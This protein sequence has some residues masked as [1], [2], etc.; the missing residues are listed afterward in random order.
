MPCLYGYTRSGRY[1]GVKKVNEKSRERSLDA[2]DRRIAEAHLHEWIFMNG[3]PALP[4]GDVGE[5][6]STGP[7]SC[8]HGWLFLL[9]PKH[10]HR[11]PL[12]RSHALA[13]MDGAALW[14]LQNQAFPQPFASGSCIKPAKVQVAA[15]E[16]RQRIETQRARAPRGWRGKSPLARV[17]DQ[18][19]GN[20][21]EQQ[22]GL[23]RSHRR[24]SGG[25]DEVFST[26]HS[27]AHQ[28]GNRA[29]PGPR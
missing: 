10:T 7:C 24:L 22:M 18:K 25:P 11:H 21:K 9:T 1:Y 17:A 4:L 13:S 23:E 26:P 8:E 3:S 29:D 28:T 2:T 14:T 5:P 6:S 16:R 15:N 12:Q 27:R 19:I 20:V